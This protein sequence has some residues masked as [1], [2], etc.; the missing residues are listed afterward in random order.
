MVI[1]QPQV[2][3]IRVETSYFIT[4]NGLEE[5]ISP[6]QAME[7]IKSQGYIQADLRAP[8]TNVKG[9]PFSYRERTAAYFNGTDLSLKP[10]SLNVLVAF[11][12]SYNNGISTIKT[13][14]LLE[15]INQ[16]YSGAT[17]ES[18][19]ARISELNKTLQSRTGQPNKVFI[20]S[21]RRGNYTFVP[22]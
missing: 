5:K 22:N 14:I 21:D 15:T 6:E 12:E 11:L 7:I 18:L 10:L 9:T 4:V 8:L 17:L 3:Q 20:K 16:Y 19:Y 1:S 13:N 2:V